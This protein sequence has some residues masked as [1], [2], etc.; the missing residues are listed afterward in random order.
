MAADDTYVSKSEPI[1]YQ[2]PEAEDGEEQSHLHCK[3]DGKAKLYCAVVTADPVL[4]RNQNF[5]ISEI[6]QP[7]FYSRVIKE[8]IRGLQEKKTTKSN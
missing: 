4:Y 7:R 5:R 3:T 6:I 1:V 2:W 8:E